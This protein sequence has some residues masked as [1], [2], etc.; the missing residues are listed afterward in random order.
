M[1]A[2]IKC[3][4]LNYNVVPIWITRIM[5]FMDRLISCVN[6]DRMVQWFILSSVCVLYFHSIRFNS[7]DGVVRLDPNVGVCDSFLETL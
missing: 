1:M 7:I 6:P 3:N 5:N 2:N 4:G